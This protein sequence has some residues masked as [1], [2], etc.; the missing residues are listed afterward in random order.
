MPSDATTETLPGDSAPPH[1]RGSALTEAL[2]R[3]IQDAV[4]RGVP[5]ESLPQDPAVLASLN[6][7][8]R[9]LAAV[10]PEPD[11]AG[12]DG[13]AAARR[14]PT[15]AE[16]FDAWRDVP[17]SIIYEPAAGATPDG[18]PLGAW[19]L[20]G[21]PHWSANGVDPEFVLSI[22][23]LMVRQMRDRPAPL[24]EPSADVQ[25]L[26][27]ARTAAEIAVADARAQLQIAQDRYDAAL[28]AASASEPGVLP[29]LP[30]R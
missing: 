19:R 18:Q 23:A 7:L 30:R 13:D 12:A 14:P 8:L 17:V 29:F 9:H 22:H 4:G 24:E 3:A 27:A 6:V 25:A 16:A 26:F 21:A 11:P 5:G 2:L 1:P 10:D 15:M 20:V 28:R